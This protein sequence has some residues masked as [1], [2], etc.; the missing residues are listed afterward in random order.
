MS[1]RVEWLAGPAFLWGLLFL[2]LVPGLALI[3]LVLFA[4]AAVVALAAAIV[5][6]PYLLVR[7]LH[8]HA[9]PVARAIAETVLHNPVTARRAQ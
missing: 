8:R 7:T 2:L 6:V 5:V 4:L 9:V 3:A 1:Y